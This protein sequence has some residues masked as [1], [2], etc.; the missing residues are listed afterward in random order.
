MKAGEHHKPEVDQVAER[1]LC[2]AMAALKDADE[3]QAFLRDLCTP[4]E[5]QAMAD[6]WRVVGLLKT[7]KPYR[8]INQLTGVSVTT[9]GRVARCLEAGN[10]G[11]S[12]LAERL[13]LGAEPGRER[14]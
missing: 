11:Y 8:E 3:A 14:H 5:L 2:E 13:Q 7:G 12:S 4:A 10:G 1:Q 9:V 6:R